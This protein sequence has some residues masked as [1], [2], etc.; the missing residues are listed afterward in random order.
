[1]QATNPY[2]PTFVFS[3][4]PSK[5]G[6]KQEDYLERANLAIH[7]TAK[8]IRNHKNNHGDFRQLFFELLAQLGHLRGKIAQDHGSE[9]PGLFGCRRDA[10]YPGMISTLVLGGPFTKYGV[11]TL[12]LLGKYLQSMQNPDGTFERKELKIED[13]CEGKTSTLAIEILN[14][15]DLKTQGYKEDPSTCLPLT[16]KNHKR[17]WQLNLDHPEVK[18][19]REGF[20]E[21][22]QANSSSYCAR[23]MAHATQNINRINYCPA[24]IDVKYD[25][26]TRNLIL[27]QILSQAS[28][29]SRFQA[30]QLFE[31]ID[32]KQ[33]LRD[34]FPKN[35]KEV[36]GNRKSHYVHVL[37]RTQV[38]GKLYSMLNYITWM[39]EKEEW[40][41]HKNPRHNPVKRM[42]ERSKVMLIHQDEYLIEPTLQE[43]AKV[44]EKAVMWDRNSQDLQTLKNTMAHFCYLFSLAHPFV[45]GSAAVREWLEEAIYQSLDVKHTYDKNN[46]ML[47]LEAFANG[48]FSQFQ[49]AYNEK[50]QLE[51]L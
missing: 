11:H 40:I 38:D 31:K 49:E 32:E 14:D 12:Q 51:M 43:T 29:E 1:M 45:R 44:F 9:N 5:Y 35:R 24:P 47:D 7:E 22:K 21:F 13:Q 33:L 50:V 16:L 37:L 8:S 19:Y 17:I 34:Y 28:I 30:E 48:L 18:K 36:L 15:E 6:N 46:V 26:S 27:K 25:Q 2:N 41:T 39:Y 42:I 20:R 4:S 23:K 10:Y 3:Q